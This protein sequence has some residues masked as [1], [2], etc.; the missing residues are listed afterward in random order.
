MTA[1]PR[2]PG[3]TTGTGGRE[4]L[5]WTEAL[6]DRFNPDLSRHVWETRYRHVED[7]EARERTVEQTWR[8]VTLCNC[9]VMRSGMPCAPPSSQPY[10]DGAI[11]KT[12][13]V[14]EE[15]GFAP[16]REL[17]ERADAL[18]VKGITAFRTTPL[19]GD[20]LALG[21]PAEDERAPC[22]QPAS[23]EVCR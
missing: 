12:V 22:W 20:V 3:A 11:S 18:G 13:N 4:A 9:F 15:L 6:G 21:A 16:F 10:V 2:P 1:R 7:G 14:P 23:E 17:F 19:R 8:R 5:A